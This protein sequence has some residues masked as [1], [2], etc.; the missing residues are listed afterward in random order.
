[1][2]VKGLDFNL[3]ARA[4]ELGRH[5]LLSLMLL[6]AAGGS[7]TDILADLLIPRTEKFVISLSADG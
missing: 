2:H 5:E 1:M 3:V 4:V 7:G 6:L